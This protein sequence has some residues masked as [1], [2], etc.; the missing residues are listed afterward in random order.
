MLLQT[1]LF[2]R[3]SLSDGLPVLIDR[4]G[5]ACLDSCSTTPPLRSPK[6]GLTVR[7]LEDHGITQEDINPPLS[8]IIILVILGLTALALC[9][10]A[11][12]TCAVKS[13]LWLSSY[14]NRRKS[15]REGRR[16]AEIRVE[17]SAGAPG[18]GSCSL[19]DLDEARASGWVVTPVVVEGDGGRGTLRRARV[20]ETFPV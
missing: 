9:I 5:K 12:V 11:L 4:S 19:G 7:D 20:S 14:L 3:V 2:L 1:I 6:L 16:F 18:P 17:E 13:G 15:R 8:T 10:F